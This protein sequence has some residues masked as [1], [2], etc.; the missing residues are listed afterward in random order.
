MIGALQERFVRFAFVRS[1]SNV[2]FGNR[3]PISD[4]CQTVRQRSAIRAEVPEEFA[5]CHI[6]G[7]GDGGVR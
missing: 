7:I 1:Q 4:R 2:F 6:A 5:G 3:P